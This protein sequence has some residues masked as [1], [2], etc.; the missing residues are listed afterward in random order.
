MEIYIHPIFNS[1][2]LAR[3]QQYFD[4]VLASMI[5]S[6]NIESLPFSL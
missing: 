2:T 3:R 6:E 4:N 5:I 1:E